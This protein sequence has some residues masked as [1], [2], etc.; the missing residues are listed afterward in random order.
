MRTQRAIRCIV[1]V[2]VYVIVI[3]T[4]RVMIFITPIGIRGM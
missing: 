3:T 4:P 1:R 2:I